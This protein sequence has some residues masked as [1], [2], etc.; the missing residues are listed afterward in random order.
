M[1][2]GL[3]HDFVLAVLVDVDRDDLKAPAHRSPLFDDVTGKSLR[4]SVGQG[5]PI[6][7]QTIA[8]GCARIAVNLGALSGHEINAAIA[9]HVRQG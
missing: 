3:Q 8:L 7:A 9:V 5:V 1:A 6:H 2:F 4:R